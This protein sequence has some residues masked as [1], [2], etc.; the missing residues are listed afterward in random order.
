MDA[1][2]KSI[3]R[4]I[5]FPRCIDPAMAAF[6]LS[7]ALGR[8]PLLP[9]ARADSRPAVVTDRKFGVTTVEALIPPRERQINGKTAPGLLHVGV[10]SG[11]FEPM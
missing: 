3:Q 6:F 1:N 7:N 8:P 2:K 4:L 9:R 11:P 10:A 5:A